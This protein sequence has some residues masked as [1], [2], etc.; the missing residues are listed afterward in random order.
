MRS[1]IAL[2]ANNCTVYLPIHLY[3]AKTHVRCIGAGK[4]WIRTRTEG[5][6]GTLE[7]H[8]GR[9]FLAL[10]SDTLEV[11]RVVLEA[12]RQTAIRTCYSNEAE[13]THQCL[14]WFVFGKR[15]GGEY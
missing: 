3:R 13:E 12:R 8:A 5:V 2:A 7:L 14:V 10:G 9:E 15:A 1:D 4:S 6:V 11:I